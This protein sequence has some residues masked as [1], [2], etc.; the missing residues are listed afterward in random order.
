PRLRGGGLAPP[1]NPPDTLAGALAG[2]IDLRPDEGRQVVQLDLT[3][4]DLA[5]GPPAQPA[6]R[7]PR[8]HLTGQGIYDLLKDSFQIVQ[9]HLE[10]QSLN[11]DA[12]G[13]VAALSSDMEL[14]LEGKLGYDLEK[15]EPQLRPY[16][17][18]G[19]ELTGRAPRP[20]R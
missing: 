12:S 15:L 3:V 10:S 8:V 6:W 1:P 7:E 16:L 20:C 14:S 11:G 4:Q 9:L 2:N 13:Q 19:V 5:F 17:G 18:A